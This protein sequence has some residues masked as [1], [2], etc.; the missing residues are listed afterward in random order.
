LAA[1]TE[2]KAASLLKRE[3]V[4]LATGAMTVLSTVVYVL[5]SMGIKIPDKVQKGFSLLA[6]VAGG[7]GIRSLVKPA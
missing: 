6:M 3:P 5:P 1:K 2:P 7:L 4:A